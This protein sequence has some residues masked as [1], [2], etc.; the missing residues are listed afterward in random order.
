LRNLSTQ[1]SLSPS[2][3]IWANEH[4]EMSTNGENFA[5]KK[6]SLQKLVEMNTNKE[7]T[8]AE[9]VDSLKMPTDEERAQAEKDVL[10]LFKQYKGNEAWHIVAMTAMEM[11]NEYNELASFI[12]AKLM[13]LD[14]ETIR[15]LLGELVPQLKEEKMPIG[16][17]GMPLC[18]SLS[19]G[20]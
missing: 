12:M 17:D 3:S 11:D 2:C 1:I 7:G 14:R 9:A 10:A 19:F 13:L 18:E 4:I 15:K 20:F 6:I 5:F 8:D 16:D